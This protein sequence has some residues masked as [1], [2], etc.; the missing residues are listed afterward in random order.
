MN[1]GSDRPPKAV[2]RA[3]REAAGRAY[4]E[5]LHRAPGV[6]AAAFDEWREGRLPS[7]EL[8]D[9]MY[10]FH[11]GAA[12]DLWKKYNYARIESVVAHAIITEVVD[13]ATCRSTS[14]GISSRSL[15]STRKPTISGP[16]QRRQR[17]LRARRFAADGGGSAGEPPR[18]KPGSQTALRTLRP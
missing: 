10:R 17:A 12:R 8:A 11:D 4:E 5:E 6:L 18:L 2:R 7:G 9:R 1:T 15:G 16:R 13:R 3:L 14:W